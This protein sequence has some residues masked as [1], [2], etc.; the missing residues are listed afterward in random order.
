MVD[1][2]KAIDDEGRTH[3]N[4]E[5]TSPK[6]RGYPCTY[7][8]LIEFTF[9]TVEGWAFIYTRDDPY[10]FGVRVQDPEGDVVERVSID[11]QTAEDILT[12]LGLGEQVIGSI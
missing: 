7:A 2:R 6:W 1:D 11:L 4:T 8:R 5:G 3:T 9:I 12:S 10:H